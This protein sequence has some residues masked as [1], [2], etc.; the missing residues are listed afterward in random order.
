MSAYFDFKEIRA[1]YKC[2]RTTIYRW[3]KR[4]ENPFP[5]SL[6]R[7]GKVMWYVAEVLKWEAREDD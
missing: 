1:R 2:S 4:R 7:G 6:T 3:L 5:A